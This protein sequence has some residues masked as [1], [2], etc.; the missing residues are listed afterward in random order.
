MLKKNR[1][2]SESLPE[3]C[4]GYVIRH[5]IPTGAIPL[6]GRDGQPDLA[7]PFPKSNN[8]A[9]STGVPRPAR[10]TPRRTVPSPLNSIT[11]ATGFF[12]SSAETAETTC[13][14]S[15]NRYTTPDSSVNDTS[16][17]NLPTSTPPAITPPSPTG[18][19]PPPAGSFV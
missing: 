10:S 1:V 13:P 6:P 14:V 3:T 4:P 2:E 7:D 9:R 15:L 8:P 5:N 18:G 17:F 16:L 11:G 12:T 19:T